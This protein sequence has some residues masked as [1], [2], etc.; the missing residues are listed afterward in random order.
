MKRYLALALA[1]VAIAASA[2]P[3]VP[4]GPTT[5]L[6]VTASAQ[7]LTLPTVLSVPSQASTV[8]D[9]GLYSYLL[10]NIGTQTVF[11]RCDGVTATVSVGTPIA[12][13]MAYVIS[14]DK[15]VTACS[16][17]AGSTGSTLYATV[18]RGE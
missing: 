9:F 3:F 18:G 12:A 6:V 7:S 14:L 1:A 2:F 4:T 15:T 5:N 17:I 16:A 8:T 11:F 13:G 10:V